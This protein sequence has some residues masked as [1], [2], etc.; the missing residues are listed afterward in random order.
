MK[1][2]QFIQYDPSFIKTNKKSL[3]VCI[4]Y[5]YIYMYVSECVCI[6]SG[7]YQNL[8]S[9]SLSLNGLIMSDFNFLL[10]T[11]LYSL[12]FLS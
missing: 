3:S 4:I 1:K 5:I 2:G 11:I 6:I 12:N 7:N 10:Y 8:D 9:G